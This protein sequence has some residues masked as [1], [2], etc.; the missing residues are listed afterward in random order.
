MLKYDPEQLINS[1]NRNILILFRK[2]VDNVLFE[3]QR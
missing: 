3:K 2:Y 1:P